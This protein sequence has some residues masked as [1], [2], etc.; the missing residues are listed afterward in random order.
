MNPVL[1]RVPNRAGRNSRSLRLGLAVL[2]AMTFLLA[3]CA[4]GAVGT[5]GNPFIASEGGIRVKRGDTIVVRVDYTVDQFGIDGREL[6]AA[7]WVPAGANAEIGDVSSSFWLS[8]VRVGQGWDLRL[9]QVRAERRSVGGGVRYRL[10]GL[11][12]VSTSADSIP[13]D[14]RVR[15]VLNTRGASA[16]VSFTVDTRP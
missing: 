13:G 16:P 3:A 7:M 9:L 4:P 12:E 1:D 2:A 10:W 8:D 6:S 15:A 11:Y 5:V 14:Y